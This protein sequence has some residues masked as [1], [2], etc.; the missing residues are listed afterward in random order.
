MREY[1]ARILFIL[2]LINAWFVA[3]LGHGSAEPVQESVQVPVLPQALREE[4]ERRYTQAIS[5]SP[6][7]QG[8]DRAALL[9]LALLRM[10]L[11][12]GTVP[13]REAIHKLLIIEADSV[14]VESKLSERIRLLSLAYLVFKEAKFLDR[15]QKA[16]VQVEK[17]LSPK[18]PSGELIHAL[19]TLYAASLDR[20][21]FQ[22]ATDHAKQALTVQDSRDLQ[23]LPA[24]GAAYIALYQVSGERRW[25][26]EARALG[27][28]VIEDTS[29]DKREFRVP[30]A[31]FFNLLTH[32]TGE[33]K[34]REALFRYATQEFQ[35]PTDTISW[36]NALL[37]H[38]ELSNP[39]LH[40]T[41]VGSK[42][43]PRARE[44]FEA[45]LHY[46]M[47]HK[48]LEWWDRSEGPL[49][50][51]DVAFPE[52]PRPALFVCAERRCSLPIFEASAVE[53]EIQQLL[54]VETR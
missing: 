47:L 24:F 51:A 7:G 2:V 6:I 54:V 37:L 29:F 3:P 19:S 40:L 4:C 34:F 32:H 52:L 39:P 18:E 8:V 31:R 46:P 28:R 12:L 25:I 49:P 48:R 36:V 16:Y 1:V 9:E 33:S 53:R 27:T 43:Q 35:A 45:A 5:S 17:K 30:R 13:E 20:T 44:L 11:N 10:T 50:N 22:V 26:A 42:D 23:Q 41:V 15:A 21:V 14:A 38:Y